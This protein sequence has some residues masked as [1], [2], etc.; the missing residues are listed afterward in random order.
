MRG[1]GRNCSKGN[2]R[3]GISW[4]A[5]TRLSLVGVTRNRATL[6]LAWFIATARSISVQKII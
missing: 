3:T 1:D 5:R 2:P 4:I 6:G